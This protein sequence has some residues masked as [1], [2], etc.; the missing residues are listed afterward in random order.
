[1]QGTTPQSPT[2]GE[3]P[4]RR[5]HRGET[6]PACQDQP[7]LSGIASE[8]HVG[9]ELIDPAWDKFVAAPGGMYQ[10]GSAEIF[11]GPENAM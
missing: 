8:A 11:H 7:K 9:W 10:Q 4:G 2:A 5:A 1:L 6:R 3:A